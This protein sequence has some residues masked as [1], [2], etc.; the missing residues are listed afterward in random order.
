[1]KAFFLTLLL[2]VS[3][4]GA[5]EPLPSDTVLVELGPAKVTNAD[6]DAMA[7][8]L[9]PEVRAG[10]FNS[11]ER[12]GKMLET[13]V[14]RR[15][16]VQ[17]VLDGTTDIELDLKALEKNQSD[18]VLTQMQME[19]EMVA[20]PRPDRQAEARAVYERNPRDWRQPDTV[21]VRQILVG[22]EGRTIQQAL[23]RAQEVYGQLTAGSISFEQAVATYSDDPGHRN[24]KGLYER[25]GRGQ[26]VPAFEQAA[27]GLT[28][29]GEISEPVLSRF[30][31]HIIRL[32]ER[33]PERILSFE[34]ARPQIES[35]LLRKEL[36]N[37]E[38]RVREK[39]GADADQI[40]LQR[41]IAAGLESDPRYKARLRLALEEA[42]LRAYRAWYVEHH[43]KGDFDQLAREYFLTHRDEFNSPLAVTVAEIFVPE[44]E[45]GEASMLTAKHLKNVASN[46]AGAQLLI[47]TPPPGIRVTEQRYVQGEHE[48]RAASLAFRLT[49]PGETSPVTTVPGGYLLLSLLLREP[50]APQE[51][52]AVRKNLIERL[53]AEKQQQLWTAHI[54]EFHKLPSQANAEA[55]AALRTRYIGR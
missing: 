35:D 51:F 47:A 14:V 8:Q 25:V 50:P 9:P 21:T 38:R 42:T 28:D 26:M 4:P 16:M 34:E 49:T 31:Y 2:V 12:I 22:V 30:G 5:A 39:L 15:A 37:R 48:M 17:E 11:P 33:H 24:N 19:Q 43:L 44:G 46:V 7:E 27:F 6:A 32:E 23:E 54:A 40:L 1:M 10:V 55:I 3:L 29:P 52:A 41:A 45:D 36:G 18:A 53:R 20:L 13:L